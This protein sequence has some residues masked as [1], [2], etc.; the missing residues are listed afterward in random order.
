MARQRLEAR[1][2]PGSDWMESEKTEHESKGK[3]QSSYKKTMQVNFTQQDKNEK[4]KI[5]VI[6]IYKP[7]KKVYLPTLQ[8]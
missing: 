1:W 2:Q 8:I 7:I 3:Y 6:N 5:G 4:F